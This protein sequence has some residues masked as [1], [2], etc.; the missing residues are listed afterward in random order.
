MGGKIW[1]LI[2]YIFHPAL[3]PTLGVFI[4]LS[5]D[6]YLY[7]P[8]DTP[9]PWIIVLSIVFAC[10]FLMPSLLSVLLL[11]IG[12]V[13][14]LTNPTENDRKTLLAFTSLCFMLCYYT[15]HNIPPSGQSLSRFM[16][17]INISII[18]TLIT[19]MFTKVSLH[20]VGAGGIL[21]TV[22]GLMHYANFNYFPWLATVAIMAVIIPLAR[23]KLKAHQAFDLYIGLGI[24]ILSQSL[25]FFY[26]GYR[27]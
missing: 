19:S 21:G 25:V 22:I 12:K 7:I 3:M 4:V 15:F 24:G 18:T 27:I 17:G 2:S 5:C 26:G 1:T 16:L 20:S 23:Y 9:Q 8:I 13:L 6:P 14:S 11:K 10:T